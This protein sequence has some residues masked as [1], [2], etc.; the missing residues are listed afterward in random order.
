MKEIIMDAAAVSSIVLAIVGL[1]KLPFKKFKTNHPK[2][3]RFVFFFLSLLL[4]GALCVLT[5][6]YIVCGTLLSSDF[7]MLLISAAMFVFGGYSTYENTSLK[8]L[9]RKIV[10]SFKNFRSRHQESRVVKKMEKLIQEVGR[11]KIEDII[12]SLP[13]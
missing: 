5:Q 4:T 10:C 8:A 13:E 6:T 12:S 11:E 1:I 7:I 2:S 3:F 9:A